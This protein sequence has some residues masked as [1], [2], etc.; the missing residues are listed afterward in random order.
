MKSNDVT[1]FLQEI[2]LSVATGLWLVSACASQRARRRKERWTQR[3]RPTRL[4]KAM[5]WQA[6][7]SL[8]PASNLLAAVCLPRGSSAEAGRRRIL[9]TDIA[10]TLMYPFS[11]KGAALYHPGEVGPG[12]A[13]V[14]Q[15][16]A[17]NA[18]WNDRSSGC[19]EGIGKNRAF[20]AALVVPIVSLRPSPRLQTMKMAPLALN[21]CALI[22][23]RSKKP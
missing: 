10:A 18:T 1:L 5:R 12:I 9:A 19:L 7:P 4:R 14:S 3:L 11:G 20:S 2:A 23:R 21:T 8:Q 16:S 15:R 13:D 22:E 6:G 17:E